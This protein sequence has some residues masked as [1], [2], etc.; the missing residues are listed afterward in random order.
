[1]KPVPNN[2]PFAEIL[3]ATPR[4]AAMYL[5]AGAR[6]RLHAATT[7]TRDFLKLILL[8]MI[9]PAEALARRVILALAAQLPALG[10]RARRASSAPGS[11]RSR[12]PQAPSG[13]GNMIS[14]F[15]MLE[16]LPG[17]SKPGAPQTIRSQT[18]AEADPSQSSDE[19]YLL[20]L[21]RRL[22]S[23]GRA[24]CDPDAEAQRFLRRHPALAAR[25]RVP[26]AF[27]HPPDLRV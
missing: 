9:V 14:A 25:R 15:R 24:L 13:H 11:K 6:T 5:A 20:S 27:G 16:A 3:R 21:L 4:G 26:L 2:D 10:M 17:A 22:N 7:L 1:M 12:P 18:K 8:T 19:R 23:V